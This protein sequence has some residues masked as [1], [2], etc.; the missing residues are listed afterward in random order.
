MVYFLYYALPILVDESDHL[1]D[2]RSKFSPRLQR[3][4]DMLKEMFHFKKRYGSQPISRNGSRDENYSRNWGESLIYRE[5]TV[6]RETKPLREK[7]IL[8]LVLKNKK[9]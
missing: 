9:C 8:Y 6:K 2:I 5:L 4:N 7:N 1:Y 3:N